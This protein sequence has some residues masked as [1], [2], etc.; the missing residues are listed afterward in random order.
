[1]RLYFKAWAASVVTDHEYHQC[2]ANVA[3]NLRGDR[4]VYR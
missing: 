2:I 1:M 3:V 4:R